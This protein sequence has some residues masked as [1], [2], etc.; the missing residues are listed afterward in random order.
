MVAV[1]T[2]TKLQMAHLLHPQQLLMDV[3]QAAMQKDGPQPNLDAWLKLVAFWAL[4]QS[5]KSLKA[6]LFGSWTPGGLER[7]SQSAVRLWPLTRST[8]ALPTCRGHFGSV[9]KELAVGKEANRKSCG[10]IIVNDIHQYQPFIA[11]KR[12]DKLTKGAS[13]IFMTFTCGIQ[14]RQAHL[15]DG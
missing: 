2:K 7:C 8:G 11:L 6:D 3:S 9:V 10:T 13:G 4:N 5:P 1:P 15:V 14:T 12:S